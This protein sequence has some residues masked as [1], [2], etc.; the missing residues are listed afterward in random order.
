MDAG[1]QLEID[2]VIMTLTALKKTKKKNRT[3]TKTRWWPKYVN[4][5][6]SDWN[7]TQTLLPW[8]PLS[9]LLQVNDQHGFSACERSNNQL[10]LY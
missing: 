6:L 5:V 1:G 8:L 3:K 9:V 10:M 7:N 4:A 2:S